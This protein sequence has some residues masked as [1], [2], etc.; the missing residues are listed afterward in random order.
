M[1]HARR[2]LERSTHHLGLGRVRVLGAFILLEGLAGLLSSPV[3]G[4]WADRSSRQVFAAASALAALRS[5]VVAEA[6]WIG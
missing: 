6:A 3:W 4:R 1:P 2:T 5:I